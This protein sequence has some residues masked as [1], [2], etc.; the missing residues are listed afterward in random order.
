MLL[1]RVLIVGNCLDL[2]MQSYFV[3]CLIKKKVKEKRIYLC[4]RE[5][6]FSKM[7]MQVLVGAQGKKKGLLLITT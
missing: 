6:I 5:E 4:I 7:Q 1:L 2:F 3:L